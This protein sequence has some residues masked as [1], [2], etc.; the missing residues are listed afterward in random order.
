M[1][2]VPAPAGTTPNKLI[3]YSPGTVSAP[4]SL[5]ASQNG[6]KNVG[7]NMSQYQVPQ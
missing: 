6:H 5:P 2:M 4:A 3:K 1:A 7:Q